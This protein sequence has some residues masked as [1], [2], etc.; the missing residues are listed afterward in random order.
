[1]KY[2]ILAFTL[3][4]AVFAGGFTATQLSAADASTPA[5]GNILQRISDRLNLSPEQRTQIRGILLGDKDHLK[6]LLGQLHDAR[7]NLREAIRASGANEASVRAASAQV[8]GVEADLAVERLKLYG[9]IAPLLTDEQRSTLA[10][11]EQRIDEFVDRVI[12]QSG[13][14]PEN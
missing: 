12:A 9:Q 13:A 5:P 10:A 4:A 2:K 1:M 7:K 3:A 14:G 6:L 11:V 8:A